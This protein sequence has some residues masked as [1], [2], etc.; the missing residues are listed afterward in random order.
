VQQFLGTGAV[1]RVADHAAA[2]GQAQARG[3]EEPPRLALF[4]GRADPLPDA[5]G[6]VYL[7]HRQ[8]EDELVVIAAPDQVN[9]AYRVPD[10]LDQMG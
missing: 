1:V 5:Q 10:N 2:D 6:I 9:I 3:V 8:D 4:Q 7:A